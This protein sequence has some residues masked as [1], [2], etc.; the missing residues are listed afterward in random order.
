MAVAKLSGMCF[1]SL[2]AIVGCTTEAPDLVPATRELIL[3]PPGLSL[4]AGGSA[5]L[6]AQ[7]NDERGEPIGGASIVFQSPEP[8]VVHVSEAGL[9]SSVGPAREAMVRVASGGQE[10]LVPIEIRPARAHRI[11]ATAGDG[12]LRGEV[13]TTLE[14]P[15]DVQVVDAFGNPISGH[16]VK[17]SPPKGGAADPVDVVTDA[18]GKASTLWTLG[19]AAG[20]QELTVASQ[21]LS[22]SVPAT[23]VAGPPSSLSTAGQVGEAGR[24]ASV[25]KP[26]VRIADTFGNGVPEVPVTWEVVEGEGTVALSTTKSDGAGL[27]QAEFALGKQPG[28]Q[29]LRATFGSLSATVALD[30]VAGPP[31]K[32]ALVRG[33]TEAKPKSVVQRPP[34][35]MVTDAS[36]NPLP[37]IAVAFSVAGGG[38]VEPASALTNVRGEVAVSKW[39]FGAEGGDA[40][41][42]AVAGIEPLVLGKPI[43]VQTERTLETP[44]QDDGRADA[45]ADVPAKP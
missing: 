36:G 31:S 9:V 27:A 23:A 3:T 1:S 20:D 39:R 4:V 15:I 34:V 12:G 6:L 37:N 21:G 29:V 16:R 13:S 22:T 19:T 26:R 17:F 35:I 8:A 28:K 18:E 45:S 43:S 2:V 5:Q 38:S 32:V 7:A 11:R 40:L 42:V 14:Q 44:A 24:V 10:L 33:N 30:A 25:V 41:T